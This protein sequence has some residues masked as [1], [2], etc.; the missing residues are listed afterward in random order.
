MEQN[1][2]MKKQS[3]STASMLTAIG[4]TL[5]YGL[6]I[7]FGFIAPGVL[8]V[9]SIIGLILLVVGLY[10]LS[11][12]LRGI[13][14]AVATPFKGMFKAIVMMVG[15]AIVYVILLNILRGA[16]D[17]DNIGTIVTFIKIATIALIVAIILFTNKLR[18]ASM[19]LSKN[20][21][22]SMKHCGIAYT[23]QLVMCCIVGLVVFI[24]LF[25]TGRGASF[26]GSLG[27]EGSMGLISALTV[28]LVLATIT[29]CVFMLIGWWKVRGELQRLTDAPA[30]A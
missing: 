13:K 11:T 25:S 28:V 14:D 6:S 23:I 22:K 2:E 19:T 24:A 10:N 7:L 9:V 4:A 29:M 16:M 21:L 12:A 3:L 30:Q 17:F 15:A 26:L 1:I 5:M 20:G 18:A 8:S 27:L